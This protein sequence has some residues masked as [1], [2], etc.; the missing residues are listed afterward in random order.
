MVL[1]TVNNGTRREL[2][3]VFFTVQGFFDAAIVFLAF[4]ITFSVFE[5]DSFLVL[6]PIVAVVGVK[7]PF[8]K[9]EFGQ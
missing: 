1:V 4:L 8:V 2:V 7:M 6:F 3:V 5:E 9:T